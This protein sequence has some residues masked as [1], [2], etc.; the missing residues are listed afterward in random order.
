MPCSKYSVPILVEQIHKMQRLEV[1]GAL[2]PLY[3]S[4]GVEGLI[5]AYQLSYPR[6]PPHFM[7]THNSLPFPLP[8]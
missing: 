6:N 5:K 1:S 4:L 7:K 3:G 2:R 8:S